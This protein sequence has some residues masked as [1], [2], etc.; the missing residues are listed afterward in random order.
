MSEQLSTETMAPTKDAPAVVLVVDDEDNIAALVS[1]VV[2]TA[3]HTVI[4]AHS[5]A[6]ALSLVTS[7]HVD[8][9]V[10]DVMLGDTDGFTLLEEL[11]SKGYNLPVLFLTAL[12]ALPDKLRGLSLGDDYM[13]KPFKVQEVAARVDL[14]LRRRSSE[15]NKL[16][17]GDIVLN[18]DTYSVTRA[19]IDVPLTPTEFKLLRLLMRNANRVVL[20]SE[21]LNEVW[22][23]GF[24]GRANV[25][26][27]VSY[28][29][30]KIDGPHEA[31]MITTARGFGYMLRAAQ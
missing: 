6:E 31:Q 3:G 11:R 16:V 23:P 13:T 8:M 29:R 12:D 26:T 5:G 30:R 19:G 14:L 20:R 18:E 21:I 10:L 17:V 22:E 15:S 9:I 27:Y 2:E 25:D 7:R 24:S 28:L 1:M 4:E